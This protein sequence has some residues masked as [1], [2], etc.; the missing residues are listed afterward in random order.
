MVNKSLKSLAAI[1]VTPFTFCACFMMKLKTILW[2]ET[3]LRFGLL[4]EQV[5]FTD[6]TKFPI[7]RVVYLSTF[8]PVSGLSICVSHIVSDLFPY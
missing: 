3:G 6:L 8:P 4:V 1:K 7:Y 2:V 5:L